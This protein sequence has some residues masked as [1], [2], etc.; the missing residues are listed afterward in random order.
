MAND[1]E[2][3]AY[4][5]T[6]ETFK[7]GGCQVPPP[8]LEKA[9]GRGGAKRAGGSDPPPQPGLPRRGRSPGAAGS[10]LCRRIVRRAAKAGA[11]IS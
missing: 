7:D 1:Q 3:A 11:R 2:Y 6:G 8:S 10:R 4:S 5:Q 9:G